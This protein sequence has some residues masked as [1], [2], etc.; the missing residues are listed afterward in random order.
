VAGLLVARLCA[1]G[2]Q[3]PPRWGRDPD[4]WVVSWSW[5]P[6]DDSLEKRDRALESS[7]FWVSVARCAVCGGR[8]LLGLHPKDR[9]HCPCGCGSGD[10]CGD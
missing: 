9:P 7:A 2:E 4:G 6:V 5:E 8:G 1:C 10:R 3:L